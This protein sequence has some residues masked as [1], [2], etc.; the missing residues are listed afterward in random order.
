MNITE[1]MLRDII[2]MDIKTDADGQTDTED[3]VKRFPQLQRIIQKKQVF[4]ITN[5]GIVPIKRHVTCV[6]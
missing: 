6:H 2:V 3:F 5:R 1:Y 4:A